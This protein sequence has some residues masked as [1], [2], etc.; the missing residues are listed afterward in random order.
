MAATCIEKIPHSCGTRSGLQVFQ[1]DDG[2]TTGYCFSCGTYVPDPYNGRESTNKTP[3]SKEKSPEEIQEEMDLIKSLTPLDLPERKLGKKTLEK[4]GVKVGVSEEDGVT[5]Y[6]VAFPIH[7]DSEVTGYKLRRISDKTMW[8][9][10]QVKGAQ[11]FGEEYALTKGARKVVITEG[12]YDAIAFEGVYSA[13]SRE[14]YQNY[15]AFVSLT[16]G[17]QGALKQIQARQSF[18]KQFDEV[19][20]CFDMDEAGRDG[21]EKVCTAYPAYK[22]LNLPA[23]DPNDCLVQ[24]F[25]KALYNSLYKTNK[26]KN[27]RILSGKDLHAL[28]KEPAKYGELTWPWA[29]IQKATRGIFYGSTYYGGAGVKMGKSEIVNDLTAHFI[30]KHGVSVFLA[31]PE[32]YIKETYKRVAGK[33]TGHIFHDP[34]I[35]FDEEAYDQAEE[36]LG[37]KLQV[38]DTW[39]SVDWDVLKGDIH[40]VVENCGVK[41]VFIDPITN[42]TAGVESGEAN[43]MLEKISKEIS[44]MAK[45]LNI[46]VFIFCHLK[47]P[48]GNIS[49]EARMK[50]YNEGNFI[51]LGSCPHEVGGDIYSNQFAGSRAMMR[52]CNTMF[53]LEGNKDP[54]LEPRYRDMR[55]I[56]ILEDRHF[57]VSGT[58]P[59]FY[60][61]HTGAYVE[62]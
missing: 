8:Q 36:A 18:L 3:K 48:D 49:R 61:S 43:T 13:L 16:N 58:F 31:K 2:R 9:I 6:V 46:A 24:G 41:V 50:K 25:K 53:A 60:N 14:D 26:P 30:T 19:V 56:K 28:S 22:S 21:L 37:D 27:S 10:G 39:Q 51:G 1:E 7:K 5:P 57:G 15:F 55:R 45:D 44:I 23:K 38:L 33:I 62:V 35:P 32:E 59:I 29:H 34:D 52:S 54:E 47:A 11:F 40:Y 42:L 17:V 12:E 20:L 4:F